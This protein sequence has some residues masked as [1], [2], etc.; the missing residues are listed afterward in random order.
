[1]LT[2][3]TFNIRNWRIVRARAMGQRKAIRTVAGDR[4]QVTDASEPR[5]LCLDNNARDKEPGRYWRNAPQEGQDLLLPALAEYYRDK[6]EVARDDEMRCCGLAGMAIMLMAKELG[7]DGC[8][9]DGFDDE[10]G[11]RL[12]DLPEDHALAFMIAIGKGTKAPWPK[13]GQPSLDEV[14]SEHRF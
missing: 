14:I 9:M 8:P 11:A 13:P 6:P 10:A 4:V 7:H 2:P 5:I 3:T 12:I 1:M